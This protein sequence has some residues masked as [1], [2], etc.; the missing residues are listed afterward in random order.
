[1]SVLTLPT[2]V[3][4]ILEAVSRDQSGY[5]CVTGMHGIMEARDDAALQQI[6]NRAFL[7][8]PDGM[9]TV[10]IGRAKGFDMSR[11]YGPDLMLALM[12]ATQKLPVRHF[13]YGG[14]EGV[15]DELKAKLEVRFPGVQIAG[16]YCPPFRPLN[17][18]ELAALKAQVSESKVDLF[19]VGLST[20]KQERFMAAHLNQLDVKIMLGVG[21]AFDFHSG[22]VIQAPRWI[23]RSGL[24]WLFRL[25]TN[26][27]RLGK[28]YLVQV[29]RFASLVV[30]DWLGLA[31][32]SA[33]NQEP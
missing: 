19:W 23:Q 27:R 20:P 15:A 33:K 2:A 8:T 7:C 4:R 28:R 13:F 29:P 5:I 1:M 22:R 3:E 10:W 16:T 31:R 12:E 24:E 14:A 11:V 17:E 18:A 9:P 21:A 6:L 32:R 30:L 25:L 26:P